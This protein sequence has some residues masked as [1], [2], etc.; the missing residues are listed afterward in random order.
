MKARYLTHGRDQSQVNF[1]WQFAFLFCGP[2]YGLFINSEKK[3]IIDPFQLGC[4]LLKTKIL[5]PCRIHFLEGWIVV[6]FV[7]C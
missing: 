6:L 2:P 5:G 4:L 7:H 1:L 3:S